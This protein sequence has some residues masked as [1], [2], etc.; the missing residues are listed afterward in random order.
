MLIGLELL[1]RQIVDPDGLPVGKV[2]DVALA[3]GPDG[4]PYVAALLVGQRALGRRM[5]GRLGRW[6]AASAQRLS[7]DQARHSLR[8]GYDLV[9]KVDS[10]VHLSVRRDLLPRAPLEQWLGEHLI[11]RVP[12]ASH[13]S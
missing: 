9:A 11:D 12:G 8:I 5:G 6:V 2:D 4:V 7:T 3:L 1:D 10:A 13:A